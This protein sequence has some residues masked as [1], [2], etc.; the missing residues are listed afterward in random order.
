MIVF[1]CDRGDVRCQKNIGIDVGDERGK[2]T[3][4][5]RGTNQS[6]CTAAQLGSRK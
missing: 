5:M 3:A 2:N 4:E 1:Y 6:I